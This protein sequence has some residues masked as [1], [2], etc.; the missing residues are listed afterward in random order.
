MLYKGVF[1][2]KDQHQLI[3]YHVVLGI[4]RQQVIYVRC[5]KIC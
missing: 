5:V 1:H 3:V 2:V 4:I